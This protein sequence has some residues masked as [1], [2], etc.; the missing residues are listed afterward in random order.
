MPDF[1]EPAVVEASEVWGEA[2]TWEPGQR[3]AVRGPSGRGKSSL[4]RILSGREARYS[5]NLSIGGHAVLPGQVKPWPLLRREVL[6]AVFQDMHLFPELTGWENLGALP[7]RAPG[8]DDAR[9]R[10]WAERL[11]IVELLERPAAEGS[12]GQRQRLAILRGLAAPCQ[13]LLLDEPFSHLDKT[14]TERAQSLITEQQSE[15]GFGCILTFLDDP[16]PF[17]VDPVFSI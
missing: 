13:W 8:L 9:L 2:L 3:I 5:G 6:S 7:S 12:Q 16:P 1:L 14:S 10:D 11:D 17:E 15:R 4:I